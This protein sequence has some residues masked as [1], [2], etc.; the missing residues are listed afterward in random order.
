MIDDT[1]TIFIPILITYAVSCNYHT[2]LEVFPVDEIPDVFYNFLD[3]WNLHQFVVNQSNI[4]KSQCKVLQ[5]GI[6]QQ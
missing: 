5:L 6:G 2:R 3:D 1:Y 4:I